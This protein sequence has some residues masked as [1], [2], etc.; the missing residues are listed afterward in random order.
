MSHSQCKMEEKE[1]NE[2]YSQAGHLMEFQHKKVQ[3][4]LPSVPPL[5]AH[6][7]TILQ[8]TGFGSLS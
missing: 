8:F 3:E 6:F 4:Y 7:Q 5:L 1:S 2:Q